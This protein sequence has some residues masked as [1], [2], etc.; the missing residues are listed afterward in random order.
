VI[1]FYLFIYLSNCG[2]KI[3]NIIGFVTKFFK[4]FATVGNFAHKRKAVHCH[5]L[6]LMALPLMASTNR[7]NIK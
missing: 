1:L 4:F 6:G 3:Q 2:E 5:D 7:Q